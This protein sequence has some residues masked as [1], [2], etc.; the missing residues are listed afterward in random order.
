VPG[1]DQT[2]LLL[3]SECLSILKTAFEVKQSLE[4]DARKAV[5]QRLTDFQDLNDQ[6]DL[7]TN[8][9]LYTCENLNAALFIAC[10]QLISALLT[11]VIYLILITGQKSAIDTVMNFVAFQVIS[12]IDDIYAVTMRN[13]ALLSMTEEEPWQP[14]IVYGWVPYQERS[15]WNKFLF[16]I[17]KVA[18]LIYN[19]SYFYI[20]PFL[21]I[22]FNYM[23]MNCE[24]M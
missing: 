14:K 11:K 6:D 17:F 13:P 21:V 22:L 20:F 12:E 16:F 4:K 18:K 5:N 9:G 15:C 10:L 8:L 7:D 24:K 23:S 3:E 1:K 2:F 19:S